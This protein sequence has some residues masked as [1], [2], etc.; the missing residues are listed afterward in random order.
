MCGTVVPMSRTVK[1]EHPS[2]TWR[3]GHRLEYKAR[4]AG[5]V[6][7]AFSEDLALDQKEK[8]S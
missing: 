4:P 8:Q 7:K 3:I 6:E 2:D 1:W 5:R